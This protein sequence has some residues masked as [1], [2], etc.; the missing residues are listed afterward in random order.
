ENKLEK[1]PIEIANLTNLNEL[2]LRKNNL[3][4]LPEEIC[5]LTALRHWSANEG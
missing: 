1:L 4:T 3:T 2:D 5:D